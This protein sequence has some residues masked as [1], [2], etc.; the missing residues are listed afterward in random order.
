MSVKGKRLTDRVSYSL[1]V[2]V[3]VVPHQVLVLLTAS[4]KVGQE[5]NANGKQ[6]DQ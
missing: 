5:L 3:K 1:E 2:H 4:S 6:L